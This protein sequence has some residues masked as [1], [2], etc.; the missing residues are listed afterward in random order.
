[1][2]PLPDAPGLGA[3]VGSPPPLML[4]GAVVGG[5]EDVEEFPPLVPLPL[6][7]DDEGDMVLVKT[8]V[9]VMVVS[10]RFVL[11]ETVVKIDVERTTDREVEVEVLFPLLVADPE[12]VADAEEPPEELVLFWRGRQQT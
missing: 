8:S 11:S 7:A 12:A 2:P 3:P 5:D 4:A 9:E 1:M 10:T 6:L